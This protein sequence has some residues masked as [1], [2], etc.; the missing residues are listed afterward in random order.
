MAP[1]KEPR[2]RSWASNANIAVYIFAVL[3][4]TWIAFQ[5][6]DRVG[7][8]P[9]PPALDAMVMAALGVAITAKGKEVERKKEG[10]DENSSGDDE[11]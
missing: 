8:E 10:R 6:W 3:F 11:T 4:S 9:S 5:V 7:G 2:G 1:W